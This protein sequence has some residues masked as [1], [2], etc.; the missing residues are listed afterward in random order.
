MLTRTEIKLIAEETAKLLH[1]MNDEMMNSKRC[2]EWLGLSMDALHKRCNTGIIPYH[3][4][5]GSL[6]FYK[7]E[8]QAYYKTNDKS[9]S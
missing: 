5:N 4:T 6:Y 8:I 9:T 7:N 2:A 3:K 1:L